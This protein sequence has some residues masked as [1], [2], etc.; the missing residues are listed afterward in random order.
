M[1]PLFVPL[2]T[3]PIWALCHSLYA[4]QARLGKAVEGVRKLEISDGSWKNPEAK[5]IKNLD[6]MIN[7]AKKLIAQA[8]EWT[9]AGARLEMLDPGAALPWQPGVDGEIEAHIA[10][11]TNDFASLLAGVASYRLSWGAAVLSTVGPGAKRSAVNF[12]DTP[13]LHLIISL[14]RSQQEPPSEEVP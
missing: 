4:H 2:G 13:R 10:V 12:G 7:R 3:V 11:V 5:A 9:M 1:T 6:I 8:P 14:H